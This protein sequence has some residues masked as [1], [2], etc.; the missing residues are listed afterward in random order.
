MCRLQ[1]DVVYN[2]RPLVSVSTHVFRLGFQSSDTRP[3]LKQKK[4][5]SNNVEEEWAKLRHL[6]EKKKCIKDSPT[7]VM[8]INKR[9]CLGVNVGTANN[10]C[11]LLLVPVP[12]NSKILKSTLSL[13]GYICWV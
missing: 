7:T 11:A 3:S 12:S 6:S 2:H 4:L 10:V 8:F 13:N 1:D 5:F 9:N